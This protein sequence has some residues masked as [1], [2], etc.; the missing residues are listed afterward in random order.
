MAENS[1]AGGVT[2]NIGA[3]QSPYATPITSVD[4]TPLVLE[5]LPDE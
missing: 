2:I 5:N 4:Q 3:V 1:L